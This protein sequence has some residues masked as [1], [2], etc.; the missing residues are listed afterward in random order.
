MLGCHRYYS[1]IEARDKLTE[2]MKT[3]EKF[4]NLFKCLEDAIDRGWVTP[5]EE[6][7]IQ[8]TILKSAYKVFDEVKKI[9]AAIPDW[10]PKEKL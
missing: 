7:F 1:I 3:M 4:P 8:S 2:T 9:D 10:L 6:A 5:Q